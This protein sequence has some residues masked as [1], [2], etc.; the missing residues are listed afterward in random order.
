MCDYRYIWE[1]KTSCS[2]H[3]YKIVILKI[4]QTLVEIIVDKKCI[5]EI[6]PIYYE[7]TLYI[8]MQFL[9]LNFIT[10]L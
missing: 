8:A 7:C 1:L 4:G 9:R 10:R 5:F 2:I 3:F 6:Y